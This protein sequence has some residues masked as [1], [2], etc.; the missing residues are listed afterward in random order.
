MRHGCNWS[1]G[2]K[3]L[4]LTGVIALFSLGSMV[5]Y[6]PLDTWPEA[7]VGGIFLFSLIFSMILGVTYIVYAAMGK[8][9]KKDL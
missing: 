3:L 8:K 1:S 9:L 2:S 4:V 5:G 6:W 7:L